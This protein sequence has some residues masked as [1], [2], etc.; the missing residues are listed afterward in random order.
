MVRIKTIPDATYR[1]QFNSQFTFRQATA[2]NPQ[3]GSETDY[4]RFVDELH[5]LVTDIVPYHMGI[6]GS[7]N[8]W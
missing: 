3:I 8:D 6:M 2:L 1:L 7:D 4:E 5:G